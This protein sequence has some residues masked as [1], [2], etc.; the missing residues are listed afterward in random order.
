MFG[1]N[2]KKKEKKEEKKK[3]QG[4]L[5]K[6]LMGLIVG[7]AIGSVLGVGFAP[8][9]GSDTRKDLSKQANKILQS[10]RTVMNEAGEK[11]SKDQE[12]RKVEHSKLGH[13]S[14]PDER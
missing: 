12:H 13:K 6:I 7:G 2:K 1:F 11:K 4:H 8:K 10:A 5:D 3:K 9:K 14:I